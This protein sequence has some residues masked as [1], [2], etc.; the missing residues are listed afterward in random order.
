MP[1]PICNRGCRNSTSNNVIRYCHCGICNQCHITGVFYTV[2]YNSHTRK[3]FQPHWFKNASERGEPDL[4]GN[5][6]SHGGHNWIPD[7]Q[8][9]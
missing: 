7:N 8:R 6:Q 4:F 2:V 1:C 5:G 9:R 3:T